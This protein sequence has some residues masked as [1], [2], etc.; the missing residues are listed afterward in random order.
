[1]SQGLVKEPDAA[2]TWSRSTS[3]G[4]C[5]LVRKA[6]VKRNELWNN[7]PATTELHSVI[8]IH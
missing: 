4:R 1:M 8:E 5:Q 3:H 6:M 7:A 2:E